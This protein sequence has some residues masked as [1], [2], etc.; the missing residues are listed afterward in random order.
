MDW[1]QAVEEERAALGRIVAML[2]ALAGL[3][4][5]A[6]GQSA[7]I[8]SLVLWFL[9]RAETVARDFVTG[10][11][12]E[13]SALMPPAGAGARDALRLAIRFRTLARRLDRQARRLAAVARRVRDN[14]AAPQTPR[15]PVPRNALACLSWL[16]AF[17]LRALPP[18]C[19]H[20]TS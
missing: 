3:A 1:K 16:S 6:A 5:R 9:R 11:F 14:A 10:D 18:A 4:E 7:I 12:D 20:D 15:M 2:C 13:P 8:R 17:A 19:A